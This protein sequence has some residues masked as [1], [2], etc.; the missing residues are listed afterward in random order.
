[1][2]CFNLGYYDTPQKAFE[3][4]KKFKEKYIKEVADYYKD[5]IPEKLYDGMYSY[6]VE[7]DD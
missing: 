2:F 4:Y 5:K 1:M 3:V 6:K 7:I